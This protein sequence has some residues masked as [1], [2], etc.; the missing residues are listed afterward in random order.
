MVSAG[1]GRVHHTTGAQL[2][3]AVRPGQS[4]IYR[5]YDATPVKLNQEDH[6]FIRDEDV[7]LVYEG[8]SLTPE[9]ATPTNDNI[10]I[11]MA[12]VDHTTASGLVTQTASAE[13]KST[14]GRVVKVG[15]GAL[16][17]DGQRLPM[18]VQVGELVKIRDHAGYNVK[19]AGE[20]YT[21][22]SLE[23]VLCKWAESK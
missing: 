20:D 22:C 5:S 18:H 3:M 14:Q 15:P 6:V 23:D 19:I 10:F 16:K 21:V 9:S 7:L 17:P 4:V 1:P 8:E 12:H 11:R 2:P 13:T